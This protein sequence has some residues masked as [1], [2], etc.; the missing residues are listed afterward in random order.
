[1]HGIISVNVRRDNRLVHQSEQKN[2]IVRSGYELLLDKTSVDANT[3][4]LNYCLL[5]NGSTNP[6]FNDDGLSGS[7]ISEIGLTNINN[8]SMQPVDQLDNII[9]NQLYYVRHQFL[10]KATQYMTISEVAI[11]RKDDNNV[12]TLF[13][14][15]L[16]KDSNGLAARF[17]V[18][19]GDDIEVIYT[20]YCFKDVNI[21]TD[22]KKDV[23]LSNEFPYRVNPLAGFRWELDQWTI[24]NLTNTVSKAGCDWSITYDKSQL[25]DGKVTIIYKLK[26]SSGSTGA[27]PLSN[28]D[29]TY[30]LY[31]RLFNSR[32]RLRLDAY[33]SGLFN[34]GKEAT[35]AITVEFIDISNVVGYVWNNIVGNNEITLANDIGTGALYSYYNESGNQN[36]LW[37]KRFVKPFS[38]MFSKLNNIHYLST[39]YLL[40]GY[41]NNLYGNTDVSK[42]PNPD[43]TNDA[44]KFDTTMIKV[45]DVKNKFIGQHKNIGS[46]DLVR[47]E[48]LN[49]FIK[50]LLIIESTEQINQD[51]TVYK[52]AL[53][54]LYTNSNQFVDVSC[55]PGIILEIDGLRLYNQWQWGGSYWKHIPNAPETVDWD[56]WYRSG[57]RITNF[58]NS[59][60]GRIYGNGYNISFPVR[61]MTKEY[62]E[63]NGYKTSVI[64]NLPGLIDTTAI[65]IT[66]AD[67][68]YGE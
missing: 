49:I 60:V 42:L 46:A 53:L 62:I 7:T 1:M 25:I 55:V 9:D 48:Q 40:P 47:V 52:Y 33:N 65:T 38:P 59:L 10:T 36:S 16:T 31:F 27:I 17:E 58:G 43:N 39:S 44:L 24:N 3:S 37:L 67:G 12:F 13:A 29:R 4:L 45:S 21:Y 2:L 19:P 11:G 20:V 57:D 64:K 63:L 66:L 61:T 6:L 54:A 18:A 15:S 41:Y 23:E 8:G 50:E 22:R 14:K 51:Q 32:Y 28:N 34:V 5:G 30:E 68:F 56:T 35:I 26:Y